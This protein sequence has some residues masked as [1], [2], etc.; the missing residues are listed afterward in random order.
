MG[1]EIQVP[2]GGPIYMM[3]MISP[4][5]RVP[6]F[7]DALL[8]QLQVYSSLYHSLLFKFLSIFFPMFG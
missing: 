4:V 2:R 5:T 1:E 7:E 6:E 3:N 8:R